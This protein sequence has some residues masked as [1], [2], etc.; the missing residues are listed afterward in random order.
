MSPRP[1]AWISMFVCF[2]DSFFV[3]LCVHHGEQ[4]E[5]Q[6]KTA[7]AKPQSSEL[8]LM[9]SLVVSSFARTRTQTLTN[10]RAIPPLPHPL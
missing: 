4:R 3:C 10:R 9:N 6:D 2:S 8:A 5:R 7:V 1:L